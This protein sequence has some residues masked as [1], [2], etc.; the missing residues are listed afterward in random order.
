MGHQ[1]PHVIAARLRT[2]APHMTHT[3]GVAIHCT[4]ALTSRAHANFLAADE[5]CCHRQGPAAGPGPLRITHA[6]P[7]P[8]RPR[9]GPRAGPGSAGAHPHRLA[10]GL[11][12]LR[13]RG[14]LE[15]RERQ[16]ERERREWAGA[17]A[18]QIAGERF[19]WVVCWCWCCC[20][21]DREDAGQ[22]R[23]ERAVGTR[24]GNAG[25]GAW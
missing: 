14:Q 11:R 16:W 17:V 10:W 9:A 20:W 25:G 3:A 1:V 24:E 2:L 19:G 21:A 18:V 6:Q 5:R 7:G 22:G 13:Q 15:E 4:S 23:M 8:A 12:A